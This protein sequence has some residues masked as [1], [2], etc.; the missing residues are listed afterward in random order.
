MILII[1]NGH[2]YWVGG[3]PNVE[4]WFQGLGFGLRVG[5]GL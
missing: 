1:R 5:F 2:Y 3:P 4:F